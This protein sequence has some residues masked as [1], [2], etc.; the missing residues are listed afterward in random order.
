MFQDP[1]SVTIDAV[2]TNFNKVGSSDPTKKGVYA[3]SDGNNE[4]V[5][6]QNVSATRFRRE[7]RLVTKKIAVDPIS[8]ANKEVSSSI[9][10]IIDEPR[11]GF[12]DADQVVNIQA[13]ADWIAVTTNRDQLLGGEF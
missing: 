2:A 8:S 1:T 6:T 11:W 5:I 9:I 10:F 12:S 3:T 4:L 7:V 13:L